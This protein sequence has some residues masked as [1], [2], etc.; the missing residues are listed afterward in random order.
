MHLEAIVFPIHH[1]KISILIQVS[2][3][4]GIKPAMADGG[5]SCFRIIVISRKNIR[6]AHR[7]LTYISGLTKNPVFTHNPHFYI[8]NRSS[9]TSIAIMIIMVIGGKRRCFSKPPPLMNDFS[10]SLPPILGN[11]NRHSIG[12]GKKIT[13]RAQI[14]RFKIW[15]LMEHPIIRRDGVKNAY[16]IF[17]DRFQHLHE[18]KPSMQNHGCAGVE[19]GVHYEILAKAMK[20]GQKA[21]TNIL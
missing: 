2:D 14:L 6:S 8:L 17:P 15:K 5:G 19:N 13:N 21:N 1:K 10:E 20:K 4:A 11:F 18:F 16:P 9:H 12:C 3:I 7:N